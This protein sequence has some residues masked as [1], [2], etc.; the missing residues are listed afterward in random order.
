MTSPVHLPRCT[1]S[2]LDWALQEGSPPPED[3]PACLALLS[4]HFTPQQLSAASKDE[5]A[6]LRRLLQPLDLAHDAASHLTRFQRG[7]RAWIFKRYLA[8][9]AKGP[10]D[11]CH[12]A[13]VVYGGPGIGKSTIASALVSRLAVVLEEEGEEGSGGGDG[14]EVGRGGGEASGDGEPAAAGR[15][16]R[17][18]EVPPVSAY[19]FCKHNDAGK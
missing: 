12:R 14:E 7:S 19:F 13:L 6:G 16:E 11:P 15:R 1:G 9:L 10:A 4:R 3:V 18:V 2:C 17:V 5:V 8:W